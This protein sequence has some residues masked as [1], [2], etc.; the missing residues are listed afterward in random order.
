MLRGTASLLIYR[1]IHVFFLSVYQ[2]YRA[3]AVDNQSYR[4][5]STFSNLESFVNYAKTGHVAGFRIVSLAVYLIT[6]NE[7]K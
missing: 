1:R 4:Y 6:R 7:S 5:T 3:V 2:F